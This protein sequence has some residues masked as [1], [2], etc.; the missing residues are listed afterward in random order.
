MLLFPLC[1]GCFVRCLAELPAAM[2]WHMWANRRLQHIMSL[3]HMLP[4]YQLLQNQMLNC[5]KFILPAAD[6]CNSFLWFHTHSRRVDWAY[7]AQSA[8]NLSVRNERIP[9]WKVVLISV[10]GQT[11]HLKSGLEMSRHLAYSNDFQKQSDLENWYKLIQ[12]PP[13]YLCIL[14]MMGSSVPTQ[15]KI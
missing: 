1:S 2:P 8:W 3:Q 7:P 11:A 15:P 12:I 6:W 13:A 10:L 9:G 5:C 14:W 4:L